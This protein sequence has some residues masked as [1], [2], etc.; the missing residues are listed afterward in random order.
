M[1]KIISHSC[2][3]C[4]SHS[5]YKYGK[6]KFS[7][8][9]YQ[10][11]I[12]KH[13]FAPAHQKIDRPRKYPSCPV[14]GKSAFLHHDYDDYLNYTCSDKK[15]NHSFFKAKPAVNFPPSISNIIGNAK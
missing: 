7:N 15:G 8:Q 5:L 13:Q 1:V 14:C 11:R 10:C 6:D 9:K 4:N 3:K 12:C 2:P